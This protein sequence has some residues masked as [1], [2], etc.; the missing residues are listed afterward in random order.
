MK[1]PLYRSKSNLFSGQNFGKISPKRIL[2]VVG[3]VMY[4]I[5]KIA[6]LR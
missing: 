3:R 4:A 1:N 6:K 2:M 5:V